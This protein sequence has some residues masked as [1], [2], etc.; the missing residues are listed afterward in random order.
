MQGNVRK[1]VGIYRLLLLSTKYTLTWY[2]L[3]VKGKRYN[4]FQATK[5]NG[6]LLGFYFSFTEL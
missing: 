6:L 1:D 4:I 3:Q 2:S 5:Y